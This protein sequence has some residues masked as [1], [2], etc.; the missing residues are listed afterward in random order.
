MTLTHLSI[1]LSDS[2]STPRTSGVHLSG[3]IRYLAVSQGIYPP[4]STGTTRSRT[5]RRSLGLA[6]EDW[7]SLR[8]SRL[9]PEFEYHIG[10]FTLDG[11]IGTPDAIHFEPDGS[12]I[13]HEIKLTY[14][15]SRKSSTFLD[16]QPWLW[17]G[18]G[19][20]AMLTAAYASPCLTCIYHPVFLMGDYNRSS[21]PS[22]DYLPVRIDF[23]AEEI[24]T[25]W[26]LM[27]SN[28]HLAE[29]EQYTSAT[30]ATATTGPTI[31]E[32]F[33]A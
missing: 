27:T 2:T 11:I 8:L 3:I 31:A 26:Q 21:G 5:I 33:T 15:T 16:L 32:T 6:W 18:M 1:P 30:T 9:Y 7:L 12:L 19:Y 25:N 13:L 4:T 10:E 20:L 28:R 14:Y 22:P 23:T 24:M 29:P 17:Q